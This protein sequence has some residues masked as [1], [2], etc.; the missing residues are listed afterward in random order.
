MHPAPRARHRHAAVAINGRIWLLG[1]YTD[2]YEV[3][4]EVDVFD[5]ATNS[6]TTPGV[7]D[8]ITT[9]L[10]AFSHENVIYYG[11]GYI[12]GSGNL[13]NEDRKYA[14][15]EIHSFHSIDAL[16][17]SNEETFEIRSKYEFDMREARGDVHAVKWGKI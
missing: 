11:G 5:P 16:V 10:A 7:L 3:I 13:D 6:W 15:K 4:H 17:Y 8:W 12:N 2:D 14:T 1:G 9:D